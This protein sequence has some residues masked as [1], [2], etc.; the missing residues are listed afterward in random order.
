MG[1]CRCHRPAQVLR[2]RRFARRLQSLLQWQL[3]ATGRL[4]A[5]YRLRPQGLEPFKF[6]DDIAVHWITNWIP[7]AG[8]LAP[9]Q[10]LSRIP[11]MAEV[12]THDIRCIRPYISRAEGR[13]K[14]LFRLHPGE[15]AMIRLLI[16]TIVATLTFVPSMPA[17][18]PPATRT[19]LVRTVDLNLGEQVAVR[20]CNGEMAAVKLLDLK[21]SRDSLC[22][23]VRRAVATVQV[24]GVEVQLVAATYNLPTT[25]AGVRIDC[26]VT[27]GY[28]SGSSKKNVWGLV[29][30]ARLR[31]W[32]ADSPLIEP[33]T[34]GY[35]AGQKWFASDTQMANDPVYVDGGDVP[36]ER[37]IYYHYGLDFGGAEGMVHVLAA[38][39]GLVVSSGGDTLP[40]YE[41]TPVAARYDVV[42]ILDDRGWYYRYSHM[43]QI[44]EEVKPGET[45]RRGQ[46]IGVLGKEGGS[47]GWSHLH[48]DI[49]SRQ[50]SGLWGTQA[51]YGFVW[52]AYLR[53][54]NPKLI[55]VARPHQLLWTGDTARLDGSKSWSAAGDALSFHW[56]F[57]EGGTAEG[58]VVERR[59]NSAGVFSEV[60][61]VTDRT[62]RAAYDF[63]VVQVIDREQP[64]PLPP[65]IHAVYYPTVDIRPGTTVTFKV[66]SFR[67]AGGEVW[68]FG[69]GSPPVHV[70][71]DGNASVHAPDGYAVTTHAFG[72]PGT[73]FV[74]VRHT[75]G[76][77]VSATGRLCV[78]VEADE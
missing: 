65:S 33:A 52:E 43:K 40:G 54:R 41:D 38:T 8:G 63:Q 47:G 34:F 17:A 37:S 78:T 46:Q 6:C 75:D 49:T 44:L 19:P 12:R 71:S 14:D 62:G 74:R 7:V 77:G 21:E 72:K 45:V 22:H 36:G 25:V 53:E 27:K 3:T 64:K 32:P 61:K 69:D 24:N 29:K 9:D 11:T 39:D 70:R 18:P 60:L 68:D 66:R 26:A 28:T 10:T 30:D 50:P 59:Y 48:F 67:S 2:P 16:S 13:H 4:F 57:S 5:K 23:A 56:T 51:A 1:V 55:A 73:Y 35:P 42:Y 76:R 31:L 20:L 15:N 58:P